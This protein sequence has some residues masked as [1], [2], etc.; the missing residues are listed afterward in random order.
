VLPRYV[1]LHLYRDAQEWVCQRVFRSEAHGELPCVYAVER[2]KDLFHL[3]NTLLAFDPVTLCDTLWPEDS[4]EHRK[5][6]D[7]AVKWLRDSYRLRVA[8]LLK[9]AGERRQV[10]EAELLGPALREWVEAESVVDCPACAV[11]D[12]NLPEGWNAGN[13]GRAAGSRDRRGQ[14]GEEGGIPEGE[15][16]GTPLP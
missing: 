9:R 6:R 8:L 2:A 7:R 14:G 11:L 16:G 13:V 1:D 10:H 12:A 5:R 4:R 3:S 15:G